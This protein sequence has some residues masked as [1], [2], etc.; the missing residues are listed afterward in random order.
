MGSRRALLVAAA[1]FFLA[2][3]A[4]AESNQT[5]AAPSAAPSGASTTLE[6]ANGLYSRKMY[7]PAISEYEKFI[8]ANPSSPEVASA[9][10][11][12]AD[13][14]YF[15]K[16][17]QSAVFYFKSFVKDY[18]ADKRVPMARLRLGASLYY[19]GDTPAALRLLEPISKGASDPNLR[20]AALFY[21]GKTLEAAKHP[22]N[23]LA[24]Y[25]KLLKEYPSS[26][27]AS[28]AAVA[29]GDAHLDAGRYDDAITAYK[30]AIDNNRPTELART[31]RFKTAEIFF[32]KKD[33]ASSEKYYEGLF[34]EIAATSAAETSLKCKAL[35]GL[36]YCDYYQGNLGSAK[37]RFA[38]NEA[39]VDKSDQRPQIQYL[40]ALIYADKKEA[41]SALV[42]LDRVLAD[43]HTDAELNDKARFKKSAMLTEQGQREL[44]LKELNE[45]LSR[46]SAN[47]PRARFE[48]AQTL[49]L[50]S[51]HDEAAA[52]YTRVTADA[53]KSEYAPASLYRLASLESKRG[54]AAVAR[55]RFLEHVE[56]YPGHANS[57]KALLEAV[58]IDLE[59]GDFAAAAESSKR[60]LRQYDNN[61][62]KDIAYYKLGVALTGL[63]AY[64][65]AADAFKKIT[66]EYPASKLHP[67]AVYG[68]AASFEGAGRLKEAIPYYERVITSHP[69]S[70][71]AK[72]AASRL[73]YLYIRT[74]DYAKVSAFYQDIL[75]NRPDYPVNAD[76]VFW[77]A[78][79]LLEQQGYGTLRKVLEAL[80][81]RFPAGTYAHETQ[82]FLG[83]TAMGA[84]DFPRAVDS[85]KKALEL[86]P[87]GTYA[88]HATLGIGVAL[89]AQGDVAGAEKYFLDT[90]RF[91]AETQVA[92]RARF[93]I[94]GL[95]L[96][97]GDL[98]EAAKAYML[99]AILYDDPKYTPMALSKAGEC[100]MKLEK[101]D[102]AQKAQ[103]EL[104]ERYPDHPLTKELLKKVSAD[105]V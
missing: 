28:Y 86:N 47:V 54:H 20:S 59:A 63:Q 90:L 29:L 76:G 64:P 53:P 42:F 49:E 82:F 44:A 37:K 32:L 79:H 10:F 98:A 17:Y 85:Y 22:E 38:E 93:E 100:Y 39:L 75:F 43:P 25:R 31:A 27:Y 95:R 87:E 66:E 97:A 52:E 45:V 15:I 104:V 68:V 92:M 40:M 1:V 36:F 2:S 96:R 23:A 89:A 48:R 18:P 5:G 77:L 30:T 35:L 58:Q 6:F 101:I 71:L 61:P 88:A 78:R 16:N 11:R 57:G 55:S 14:F 3:A 34:G 73:G 7:G 99:V 56:T 26:E 33:Y 74:G 65:E 50:L 80:A 19:L 70:P 72:E 46:V 60:F 69:E 102:E 94:A 13:S 62:L 12:Y 21:I 4:R 41:S 24:L 51:R 81:T 105:H 103:E 83:E 84:K 91:D 67:E 8:Q 9:R